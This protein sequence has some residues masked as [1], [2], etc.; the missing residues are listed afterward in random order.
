MISLLQQN[1]WWFFCNCFHNYIARDKEGVRG[2]ERDRERRGEIQ[3]IIQ[4]WNF[5]SCSSHGLNEMQIWVWCGV[6][7]KISQTA[8]GGLDGNQY[9]FVKIC[10]L[11]SVPLNYIYWLKSVKRI[12]FTRY[13]KCVQIRV[14]VCTSSSINHIY[15]DACLVHL[16]LSAH[17]YRHTGALGITAQSINV[18]I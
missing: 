4:M 6:S 17:L 5:I 18:R 7:M 16:Q 12:S 8:F 14:L 1:I 2:R 3:C 9:W 13:M 10:I 11:P 15:V